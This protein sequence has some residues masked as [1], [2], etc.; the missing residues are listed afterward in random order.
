M[1]FIH[2]GIQFEGEAGPVKSLEAG[3]LLRQDGEAILFQQVHLPIFNVAVV[4][5]LMRQSR[6][7]NSTIATRPACSRDCSG[8]W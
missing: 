5:S 3:T 7:L 6:S 1:N 2:V 4:K 8:Q